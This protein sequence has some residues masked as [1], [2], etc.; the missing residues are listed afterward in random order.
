[1]ALWIGG[2]LCLNAGLCCLSHLFVLECAKT[3]QEWLHELPGDAAI[4][5]QSEHS[6]PPIN[7][8]FG[9]SLYLDI[10][11]GVLLLPLM[12]AGRCIAVP[13]SCG[14]QHISCNYCTLSMRLRMIGQIV[15][16]VAILAQVLFTASSGIISFQDGLYGLSCTPTHPANAYLAQHFAGGKI[17]EDVSVGDFNESETGLNFKTVIYDGSGDLWRK[18]LNN[19]AETVTWIIAFRNTPADRVSRYIKL[20]SPTFLAQFTLVVHEPSGLSLYHRNGQP[21]R[22]IRPVP[23]GILTDHRMCHISVG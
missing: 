10:D 22:S 5:P 17:L 7:A 21:L 9:T 19:P 11:D 16:A 1:M 18:A 20:D 14:C 4:Y 2:Q 12:G 15:F 8:T 23:D 3:Y 13:C 6:I